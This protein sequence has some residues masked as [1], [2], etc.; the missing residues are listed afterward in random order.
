MNGDTVTGVNGM[1]IT[2]AE[3]GLE[4]YQKVREQNNISISVT[5]RGKPVTINYT[6]R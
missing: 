1:E 5:R 4:I 6:I 3:K 2:T